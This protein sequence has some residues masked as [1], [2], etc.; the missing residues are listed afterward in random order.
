M[1]GRMQ[2]KPDYSDM[3]KEALERLAARMAQLLDDDR[4]IEFHRRH[5]MGSK[6]M[7]SCLCCG[8]LPEEIAIRHMELPNILI[9]KVCRDA[10]LAPPEERQ[11]SVPVADMFWWADDPEQ[12]GHDIDELVQDFDVGSIV[13]IDC[14]MRL[15]TVS[16]KVVEDKEMGDGYV[17][18]EYVA[19]P[20][21][22]QGAAP[23]GVRP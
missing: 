3:S 14:A 19:S 4:A 1:G 22:S 16:V 2:V 11:A 12:F 6:A 7:P 8:K 5:A 10:A 9:C 17:T 20:T 13:K 15:P 21:T 18:Y 23:D